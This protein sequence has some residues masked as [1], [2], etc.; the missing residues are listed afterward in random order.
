M[1][2]ITLSN[3]IRMPVLGIGTYMISPADAERSVEEALRIGYRMVDTA[4]MYGNERAVGRAVKASGIDRKDIFVSTKLW[5]S[6]YK[7]RNSVEETLERLGLDYVDL[8]YLHQPAGDYLT[9]YKQLEN[10]YGQGKVKAIGISNF[11]GKNLEKILAVAKMKPQ[12][13]QYERHPYYIG[14]DVAGILNKNDMKVM[15]WYPL[16]HGDAKLTGEPVFAE[17]G[18]KYQKS[19]VQVILRWHLQMGFCAIPG[20]KNVNHIKDNFNIFDFA[21]SEEDM[22]KIAALDTEKQYFKANKLMLGMLG[23]MKPKY[24]KK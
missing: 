16:G 2:Y 10:A 3:G 8:L 17:I 18:R 12:V 23:M 9:G 5:I 6:E 7:N 13:V 19:A 21:L 14:K 20:S 24:E 15:A 11:Y 4:N 22:K 1:E